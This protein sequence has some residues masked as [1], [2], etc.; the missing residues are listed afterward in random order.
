MLGA[1]RLHPIFPN[2][3]TR[4][5]TIAYELSQPAIVELRIC[6][7]SGRTVRVLESGAVKPA[8]KRGRIHTF[9]ATSDIHMKEKLRMARPDVV[10]AAVHAVQL[11]K[12]FTDDV[13]FSLEDQTVLNSY[14]FMNLGRFRFLV[15]P[16]AGEGDKR[17][18]L[19]RIS[20]ARFDPGVYPNARWVGRARKMLMQRDGRSVGEV[21]DEIE[22]RRQYQVSLEPLHLPV[23]ETE[24]P[25]FWSG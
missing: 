9:I 18:G 24:A 22:N 25:S 4:A 15:R 21:L 11:A 1:I 13:E 3:L 6:D 2:P 12:S 16:A 19:K 17:G 8:G 14:R 23:V 10:K 7:V 5:A 20:I